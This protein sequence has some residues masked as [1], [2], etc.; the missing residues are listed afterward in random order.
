MGIIYEARVFAEA[1]HMGQTRKY[2]GEPYIKHPTRVAKLVLEHT[3]NNAVVA[4]AILH[5]VVEDTPVTIHQL[6]THFG[7]EVA[8]LV[9]WVTDVSRPS[10]GNRATRKELDRQHIAAAPYAAKNIKLADLIDNTESIVQHDPK[11][12]KVYLREKMRLLEVLADSHP[13]LYRIAFD[14]TR[15][16]FQRLYRR[17]RTDA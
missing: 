6:S 4:A 16:G 12:S 15:K 9:D 11:F 5:D 2:T 1:A 17:I 3:N 14:I 7:Q 8:D 13:N 10:D